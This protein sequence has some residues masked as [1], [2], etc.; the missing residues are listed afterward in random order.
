MDGLIPPNT[1]DDSDELRSARAIR[2]A[3]LSARHAGTPVEP[4]RVL[5]LEELEAPIDL[6]EIGQDTDESGFS[7]RIVGY[8]IRKE[9]NRG[10][11]AT[12][13]LATQEATGR[14][15]AVKILKGGATI[16]S[17]H[18]VRF[19]REVS[20]LASLQHP[21][22]VSIVDR[23][24]TEDR[25]FFLAMDYIDG[26]DLDEFVKGRLESGLEGTRRL[27][28]LVV[29]IAAAIEEAHKL[30]I[31]HRDIKPS[32]IRIDSRGE[33]RILDF[34]LARRSGIEGDESRSLTVSGHIVGSLPWSSPEQAAGVEDLTPR[35]DVYSLGVMLYEFIAGRRPYAVDQTLLEAA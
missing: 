15:V 32:N 10:G 27:L 4:M 19:E 6:S 16:A 17:R 34:G 31:V 22:I 29:K 1:H 28:R 25:S 26:C 30:G 35:S 23:G 20:V 13:Y 7:P 2:L 18:R 5:S 3:F 33:P 8:L 14:S 9:I 12:I 11:Q 24:R 21:N